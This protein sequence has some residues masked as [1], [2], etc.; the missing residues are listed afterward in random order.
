MTQRDGNLQ[1]DFH[2]SLVH[3]AWVTAML[4]TTLLHNL[5]CLQ[6]EGSSMGVAAKPIA[7]V[8]DKASAYSCIYKGQGWLK[9]VI[10]ILFKHLPFWCLFVDPHLAIYQSPLVKKNTWHLRKCHQ[11][12]P[13]HAII[14]GKPSMHK[15]AHQSHQTHNNKCA[16]LYAGWRTMRIIGV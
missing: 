1:Q 15:T 11:N 2:S 12:P 9:C 5:I 10:W 3:V 16:Q 13:M 4:Q 8:Q 14:K 6:K 7:K